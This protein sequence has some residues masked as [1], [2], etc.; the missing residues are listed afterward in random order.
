MILLLVVASLLPAISS[1]AVENLDPAFGDKGLVITDFGVSDDQASAM[2]VQTDGKILLA[3]FSSNS[4]VKDIAIARYLSDGT[5]D[6]SFHTT[7]YVTF[8][9]GDGNAVARAMA[10]QGDGKIVVTGSY[11]NGANE[12]SSEIFLARLTSEGYLDLSFGVDG[13]LLLPLEGKT[14]GNAYDL[15]ITAAG[16]IL[17]AGTA[18][19]AG[20]LQAIVARIDPHGVL[21]SGFG[22]NGVAFIARDYETAANSLVIQADNSILLAGYSQPG[23][24]AGLSIFRLTAEGVLD[25]SFGTKGEVQTS[26]KG[27]EAV[28]YDMVAQTDGRL[29]VVGSFDNGSYREVLLGRFLANGAVDPDFGTDGLVRNDMGYDS[30][31]YGLAVQ[32]DGAI[33]ATGFSETNKGKDIFLLR[34]GKQGTVTT[35]D[36]TT[37]TADPSATVSN[38]SAS[39]KG[40]SLTAANVGQSSANSDSSASALSQDSTA[41]ASYIAESVSIYD[42]ESHALALL[43]DGKVL[44]A[45]YAG[46][47]DDTDFALLKFSAAAVDTLAD[48]ADGSGVTTGNY[49]I[50]T[51]SITNVT[52]NSAMSGGT[53]SSSLNS[54]DC[55]TYCNAQCDPL[56]T[57]CYDSCYADCSGTT[58]TARG[59]CYGTA[60]HPVYRVPSATTTTTSTT[61]STTTT[62]TTTGSTSIFPEASKKTAYNYDT[63]LYGQTS[64][65][66]GVGT[67]GSNINEITPGTV[68]YVRAYAVLS[69]DTVIYGNELSFETSDACFIA[70][71][72]YGSLLDKHVVVLR[73]FRD[74]YLKTNDLGRSFISLYYRFSP[75]IAEIIGNN[76]LLRQAV[77]ICL[78]PLVAFSSIMLHPVMALKIVLLAG[79]ALAGAMVLR[80]LKINKILKKS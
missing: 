67:F 38:L 65:G 43:A 69:D 58:V 7:G 57:T 71:A 64:D 79:G 60:R 41:T 29:V 37:A 15:Q 8:N 17:V 40:Q 10:L 55:G 75:K 33:L 54:A 1:Q 56:D 13:K 39:T 48:S 50:S 68:Y 25:E 42:D 27:G 11:D 77:R 45:G 23:E 52:R 74:V 14:G 12:A 76:A 44:A 18:S 30:V 63:V 80:S 73:E 28:V 21:D 51:T 47:G 31:G 6:T 4:V 53:I 62:D 20:K 46:N 9:I 19:D 26:V 5:L 35:S 16:D 3:G 34:Y 70:T 59:V 24:A 2:A 36:T 78:W 32:P 49:S 72:A 66:T 22:D 61:T